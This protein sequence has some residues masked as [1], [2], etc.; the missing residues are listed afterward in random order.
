MDKFKISETI[1]KP[2]MVPVFYHEN[3]ETCKKVIKACYNGGLRVFEYTNRGEKAA[4]NFPLLKQ[5]ISESCEGML[6]GIGSVI[7]G[8][9]TEQFISLG[10][11]FI[12]SPILEEEV[13]ETCNEK[14]MYWIP[15][16]ATL[17]EIAKAEKLG[18]DII[19]VFPGNVLGPGFVKAVKGP[20]KWLKLMPTG[21]VTPEK[22]NLSAW[23][24]AGVV[25]VGMGSQLLN[26]ESIKDT[27]SLTKKVSETIELID[28]IRNS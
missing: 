12:V 7:N 18:A 5:F 9:Q 4:E 24:G 8:E 21:G 14:D 15:G 17:S 2:G 11:D 13:A 1:T 23:F 28:S 3:L 10:A 27:D 19:K 20:M 25:C 22:E 26:K 16:C 6:L